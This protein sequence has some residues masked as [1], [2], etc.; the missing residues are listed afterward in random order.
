MWREG[1]KAVVQPY[2]KDKSA[3]DSIHQHSTRHHIVQQC[4][5]RVG[6]DVEAT[7]RRIRFRKHRHAMR[8]ANQV[9]I[10]HAGC[11]VFLVIHI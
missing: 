7:Q 3:R 6:A 1:D 10:A 4:T 8:S 5:Q 11:F 2:R 9:R